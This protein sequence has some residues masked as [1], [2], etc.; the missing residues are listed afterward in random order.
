MRIS[1]NHNS[2]GC[3]Q[4]LGLDVN[5]FPN[6]QHVHVYTSMCLLQLTEVGTMNIFVHWINE[7]GGEVEQLT[8]VHVYVYVCLHFIQ[9]QFQYALLYLTYY[10]HVHVYTHILEYMRKRIHV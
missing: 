5:Q 4:P 7:N 8:H 6:A 10:V 9:A 3:E 1:K 2:L